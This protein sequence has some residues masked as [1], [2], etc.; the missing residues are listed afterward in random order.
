MFGISWLT[1]R[2]KRNQ[3]NKDG[4]VIL[5]KLLNDIPE[6]VSAAF[7]ADIVDARQRLN[8]AYGAEKSKQKLH[9]AF[10]TVTNNL[11][12]FIVLG[13]QEQIDFSPL[14]KFTINLNPDIINAKNVN[15][16]QGAFD[17]IHD[18]ALKYGCAFSPSTP[19]ALLEQATDA[20]ARE[21]ALSVE[22]TRYAPYRA[23]NHPSYDRYDNDVQFK[24]RLAM[25][26]RFKEEVSST[27]RW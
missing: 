12:F 15:G 27:P 26:S 4:F 24:L 22:F 17:A 8:A 21:E 1:A 7:E 11:N 10:A 2:I 23:F 20:N 3:E 5:K 25:H 13:N 14:E 6:A 9:D 19:Q 18:T 16:L